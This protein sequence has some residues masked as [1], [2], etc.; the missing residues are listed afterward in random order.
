[1]RKIM[2]LAVAV[3]T[4]LALAGVAMAQEAAPAAESGTNLASIG[5]SFLGAALGIGLAAL[6]CGN[7]MGSAIN[8]TCTGIARNPELAGRLTTTMLIGMALIES[9]AIYALVVSFVILFVKTF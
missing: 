9:L 3:L 2:I 4:V 6:G 7:G 1:M 5:L 8:G